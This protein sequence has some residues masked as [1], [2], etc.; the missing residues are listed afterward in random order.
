MR[1]AGLLLAFAILLLAGPAWAGE[2]I[3]IQMDGWWGGIKAAQFLLTVETGGAEQTPANWD[4][5]LT[6]NTAGLIKWLTGLVAEVRGHG[7]FATLRARSEL[8]VQHVHSNK[9]DRT[10][11]V[12]FAGD[13]AIGSR[14]KDIETFTDPKKDARDAENVPDLPEEQRRDTIDP[15]AAILSLGRRA[16]G[17][18]TRFTLPIYDGR[19]RFD[20]AVSVV[21]PASHNIAGKQ[22]ATIDTVAIVHP[23]AGF[24]PFHAKWWNNAKFEISIDSKSGLPLK[25]ASDSFMAGV[26]LTA[27]AV[28]PPDPVCAL[29]QS[30]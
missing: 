3:A 14:T 9:S 25:I 19:R 13:P 16:A 27:H 29:G 5:A 22:Y 17:G 8:Y 11:T 20:L 23:V 15:I 30:H 6:V 1:L 28:C 2:P 18:E 24:K 4:G 10:V 26:V 12:A 21:G 7:Q